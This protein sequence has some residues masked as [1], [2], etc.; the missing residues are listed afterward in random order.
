MSDDQMHA[1]Q[2]QRHREALAVDMAGMREHEA[3]ARWCEERKA[4]VIYSYFEQLWWVQWM[5]EE[6]WFREVSDPDR[7]TAID[8]A[9]REGK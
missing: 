1:M 3:R 6:G 8:R 2:D 7:D 5:S 4:D 9:M